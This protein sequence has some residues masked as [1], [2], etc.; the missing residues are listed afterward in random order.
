M[1][2]TLLTCRAHGALPQVPHCRRPPCGRPVLTT[3]PNH[4][5]A[6][7]AASHRIHARHNV[8]FDFRF[9]PRCGR[10]RLFAGADGL[11]GVFVQNEGLGLTFDDGFIDH[12]LGHVLQ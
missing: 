11:R 10:Y 6:R 8:V 7:M 5:V 1:Q 3:W 2:A 9:R 12:H 4:T